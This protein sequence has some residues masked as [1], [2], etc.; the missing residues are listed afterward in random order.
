MAKL[1]SFLF[2]TAR[3]DRGN[4][5]HNSKL[6]TDMYFI[7]WGNKMQTFPAR[8]DKASFCLSSDVAI[9]NTCSERIIGCKHIH[10][11]EEIL[12]QKRQDLDLFSIA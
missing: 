9:S 1:T 10:E 2:R 12:N 5:I 11:I 7:G 4:F 6:R 8:Q 3:L